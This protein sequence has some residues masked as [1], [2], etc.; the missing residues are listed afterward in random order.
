MEGDMPFSQIF[1]DIQQLVHLPA[2]FNES[3][4]S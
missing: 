3:T 4:S 2:C 1:S